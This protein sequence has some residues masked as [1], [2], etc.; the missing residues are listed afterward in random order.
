[1]KK[2]S[3]EFLRNTEKILILGPEKP[4]IDEVC[5]IEAARRIFARAGKKVSSVLPEV[6]KNLKFLGDFEFE[7][8]L[9]ESSDFVISLS[10]KNASAERVKYNISGD[11]IDIFVSGKSGRFTPNDVSFKKNIDDFDVIFVFGSDSYEAIG[12]VFENNASIFADSLVV[13]FSASPRNESFGKVNFVDPGASSVCEILFET[14]TADKTFSEFLKKDVASLL[15]TGI[16]AKTE[17]F[18]NKNTTAKSLEICGNLQ[19]MG[20]NQSDIIEN[21][22]KQKS[23]TTLKIWGRILGNLAVDKSYN[24]SWSS[25]TRADFE[26]AES[27]PDDIED[28]SNELLRHAEDV[29]FTVL[30]VEH[31]DRTNIEIRSSNSAIDFEEINKKIGET[32]E[33]NPSGLDFEIEGKTVAEIEADFLRIL[34]IFQQKR[35]NL[36]ENTVP[37][38]M[39]AEKR[40][41]TPEEVEKIEA[42][43]L[44]TPENVPFDAPLQPHEKT[45]EMQSNQNDKKSAEIVFENKDELPDFLRKKVDKK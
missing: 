37:Q 25:A 16:I 42:K 1:M 6:P 30:F 35:L 29:D 3:L 40:E 4:S 8:D 44:R 17:S 39:K 10:T 34:R 41:E 7:K 12:P 43:P 15:A 26:I 24:F 13:N 19:K 9:G 22:F 5:A 31:P 23:L 27:T 11:S 38:K 20:V 2:P 18:L 21:L 33:I 36:P 28:F 45:G 32:G 14:I